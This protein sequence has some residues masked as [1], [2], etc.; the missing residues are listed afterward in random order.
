MALRRS[1]QTMILPLSSTLARAMAA[2][3]QLGDLHFQLCLHGLG[4]RSGCQ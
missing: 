4:Q 2:P 3:G 1:E